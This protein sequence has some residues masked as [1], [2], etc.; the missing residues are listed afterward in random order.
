MTL[1]LFR[2]GLGLILDKILVLEFAFDYKI[3]NLQS[4][5]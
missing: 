2:H 5:K 4:E 1:L 3:A